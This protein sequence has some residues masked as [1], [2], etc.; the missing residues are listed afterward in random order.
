MEKKHASVAA[1][2][3]LPDI[4]LSTAAR[5]ATDEYIEIFHNRQRLHQALSYWNPEEFELQEAGV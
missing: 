2:P 3:S 4:A 5:D 1:L